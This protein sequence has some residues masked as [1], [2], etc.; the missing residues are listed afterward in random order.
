LPPVLILVTLDECLKVR[1]DF[2]HLHI[3]A[4]ADFLGNIF[5]DIA[6]PALGYIETDDAHLP[7]QDDIRD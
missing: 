1:G 4:P 3:A 5:R 6:R 2:R 7:I